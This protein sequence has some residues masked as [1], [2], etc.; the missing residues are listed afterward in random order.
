MSSADAA[1][2]R[3]HRIALLLE[4]DGPGG[5]EVML[6]QL[7]DELRRRGH[8]V[9]P[10]GPKGREGWLSSELLRR[11]YPLAQYNL[12]GP[13]DLA[14]YRDLRKTLLDNRVEIAHSHEFTMAVYAGH[15]ARALD[16]PHVI[17]MHG[18]SWA[19]RALR[20]R[21]AM[22][23]AFRNSRAVIAVSKATHA[24]F[25]ERLG[26]A[27]ESMQ[28]IPNGIQFTPGD[29]EPVR[30]ELGLAEHDLLTVA[31]GNLVPRKGHITLLRALALLQHHAQASEW[32]V[33]IAGSGEEDGNLRTFAREAGIEAR[34]HLLGTRRDIPNILAASDVFTMPSHW[35]GLPV[36]LLEAMFSAKPV[37]ASGISGIPEAITH[38]VHGLLT[39][40]GNHEA[41]AKALERFLLDPAARAHF[42]RA[43]RDRANSTFHV[44]AMTDAYERAY[45]IRS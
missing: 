40:P 26:I 1:S 19:S 38:D 11:G 3:P 39:P 9:I 12:N 45:G 18:D 21:I 28:A 22:R 27:P 35:E 5:A 44:S 24:D 2:V 32:H 42:G 15:A 37:I 17:T 14:G 13:L 36:A 20:R 31:V 33:A 34:V 8:H 4:T 41:V 25:V 43:A 23:W 10:V 16:I 6:L 7:A 30:R 29:R